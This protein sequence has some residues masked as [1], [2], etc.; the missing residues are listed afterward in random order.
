MELDFSHGRWMANGPM[1][2]SVVVFVVWDVFFFC[3]H[4]LHRYDVK[5]KWG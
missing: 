3:G 1:D 4:C 5:Q 2:G